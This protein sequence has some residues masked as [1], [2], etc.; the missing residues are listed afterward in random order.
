MKMMIC[1]VALLG[2]SA[3]GNGDSGGNWA[4]VTGFGCKNGKPDEALT[5]ATTTIPGYMQEMGKGTCATRQKNF[6]GDTQCKGDRLQ[7]K[8]E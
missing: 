3:C 4:D 5:T 8:C 6:T 7:V 2:L 1:V